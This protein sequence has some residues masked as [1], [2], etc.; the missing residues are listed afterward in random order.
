M[1]LRAG[2]SA[3][4]D[5]KA[6]ERGGSALGEHAAFRRQGL[7]AFGSHVQ[8]AMGIDVSEVRIARTRIEIV[9]IEVKPAH[10]VSQLSFEPVA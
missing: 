3:L 2:G 9:E 10:F 4:F 8:H 5:I 6:L 7:Q 1:C